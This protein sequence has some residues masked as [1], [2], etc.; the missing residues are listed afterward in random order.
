MPNGVVIKFFL[1]RLSVYNCFS[2][3]FKRSKIKKLKAE[4]KRINKTKF[5]MLC[6]LCY[7]IEYE[8]VDAVL[9]INEKLK[10]R[11]G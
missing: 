6:S 5:I 2:V 7:G 8:I 3:C 11:A 1:L 9:E 10:F 4:I